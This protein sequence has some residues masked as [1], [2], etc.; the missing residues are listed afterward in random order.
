MVYITVYK[1]DAH[2]TVLYI[3]NCGKEKNSFGYNKNEIQPYTN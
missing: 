1:R 3:Y 2:T